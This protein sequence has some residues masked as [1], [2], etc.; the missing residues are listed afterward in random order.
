MVFFPEN[1][2]QPCDKMQG[3]VMLLFNKLV[4]VKKPFH[5]TLINIAFCNLTERN[6]NSISHFFS[7]K[8]DRN[9]EVYLSS[10]SNRHDS[11]DRSDVCPEI[12][13]FNQTWE[14]C[15]SSGHATTCNSYTNLISCDSRKAN[16]AC[17]MKTHS[18]QNTVT[19]VCPVN[20]NDNAS[21]SSNKRKSLSSQSGFFSK[22]FKRTTRESPQILNSNHIDSEVFSQL[23]PDIQK[24][25]FQAN[26]DLKLSADIAVEQKTC[27]LKDDINATFQR[28]SPEEKRCNTETLNEK[29]EE[30]R[31][32]KSDSTD[33]K[34]SVKVTEATE[35]S[36]VPA[37]YDREVFLSLPADIQRELLKEEK[38]KAE[39]AYVKQVKSSGRYQTKDAKTSKSG[40]LLSFFKRSK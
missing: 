5:L 18:S 34:S 13:S 6:K 23:P 37:G 4:D 32:C 33:F 8:K 28:D 36:F 2:E 10:D 21:C 29:S 24:E 11:L 35:S 38:N 16:S 17:L 14:N 19:S 12:Q 22:R 27:S 1:Q 25:I 7:P 9:S 30:S 31:L 40:N 39:W 20:E 26:S 3:I 15:S